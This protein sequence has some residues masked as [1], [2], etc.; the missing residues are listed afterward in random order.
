MPSRVLDS[1]GT[2]EYV[3]TKFKLPS[4]EKA[5][6]VLTKEDILEQ[7]TIRYPNVQQGGTIKDN[8]LYLPVGLHEFKGSEKRSDA[9]RAIII[10]NLKTKMIERTININSMVK[11]EPEDVS[12]YKKNLLLYCGQE[13]GLTK[14]ALSD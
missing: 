13:G 9:E 8:Y 12:F 6:I 3:I 4:L 10:V 11:E 1:I 2:K 5:K 7:F 14:I